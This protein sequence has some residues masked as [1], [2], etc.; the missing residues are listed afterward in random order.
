MEIRDSARKHDIPD[1]DIRHAWRHAV[2]YVEYEYDGEE[3]LL[4]IGPAQDGSMRT[5]RRPGRCACPDHPCP[6]G[7]TQPL[8]LLEVMSMTKTTN[9]DAEVAALD[10]ITPDVNPSRDARHFRRIIAASE[11]LADAER[12]LQLAVDAARRA[13]DSWAVIGAALD[14][15]RQAAYQRFGR[16]ND[17]PDDGMVT[18]EV[19]GAV[20]TDAV[21]AWAKENHIPK[22]GQRKIGRGRQY[23]YRMTPRQ[24]EALAEWLD[25][26]ARRADAGTRAT[27][28]PDGRRRAARTANRVRNAVTHSGSIV[29]NP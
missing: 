6:G 24:A 23:I 28:T 2:R 8:P 7:A 5:G 27:M 21:T 17:I 22:P 9:Y 4:V 25:S 19:P 15:S 20:N 1:A 12:E 18:V 11:Q 13:G 26:L 29:R 10:A 14:I 3:R 16:A